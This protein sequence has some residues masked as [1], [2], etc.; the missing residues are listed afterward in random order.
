[1]VRGGVGC[2]AMEG[3]ALRSHLD[4]LLLIVMEELKGLHAPPCGV[5]C[6][7]TALLSDLM[8]FDELGSKLWILL[9]EDVSCSRFHPG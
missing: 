2:Q 8:F 1:M 7:L 9:S 6:W 4:K 3:E 5:L